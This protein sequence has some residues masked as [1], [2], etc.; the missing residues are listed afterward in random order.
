MV[1]NLMVV[2]PSYY[3]TDETKDLKSSVKK[4]ILVKSQTEV[5]HMHPSLFSLD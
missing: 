4:V 2:I 5:L 3:Y 1:K